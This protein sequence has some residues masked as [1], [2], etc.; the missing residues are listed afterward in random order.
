[1]LLK[2]KSLTLILNAKLEYLLKNDKSSHLEKRKKPSSKLG[3]LMT[4]K[5]RLH[6]AF[7]LV[8]EARDAA[9][10]IKVGISIACPSWVG[11]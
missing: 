3:F 7:E 8:V 6:K 9:P 4:L 1:M 2:G 11:A 5:R 10:T